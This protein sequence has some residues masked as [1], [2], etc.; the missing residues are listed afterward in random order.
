M[1]AAVDLIQGGRLGLVLSIAP[2][3]LNS[4]ENC[5]SKDARYEGNQRDRNRFYGSDDTILHVAI[6]FELLAM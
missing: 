4:I 6:I 5:W 3:A 1:A 2:F